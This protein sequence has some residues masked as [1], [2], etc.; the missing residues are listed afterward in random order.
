MKLS[1]VAGRLG[2]ALRGNGEIEIR[3]LAT[4]ERARPG[5]L[6]FLTNPRYNKAARESQASALIVGEEFPP[7]DVTLLMHPNPYL[8]FAKAIELFHQPPRPVVRIHPT[9]CIDDTA[10]IGKGV[11]VGAYAVIGAHAV[12]ENGVDI[13]EHC[14]IHPR[15]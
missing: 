8:I 15:A 4:L 6:R 11:S 13:R 3:G 1:E 7:L 12:I 14:V 2:C 9:A 10:R 5:E